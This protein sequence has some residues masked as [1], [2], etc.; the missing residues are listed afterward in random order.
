MAYHNECAC[1]QISL[2]RFGR[3]LASV[4]KSSSS[5]SSSTYTSEDTRRRW[6]RR[7]T[8]M[9]LTTCESVFR[10]PCIHHPSII[11][12]RMLPVLKKFPVYLTSRCGDSRPRVDLDSL[13]AVVVCCDL[14]LTVRKNERNIAHYITDFH[15]LYNHL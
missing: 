11:V 3:L 6:R 9:R 2:R 5:V 12:P 8:A 10:L 14:A 15:K 4:S 1:L 7:T 13:W